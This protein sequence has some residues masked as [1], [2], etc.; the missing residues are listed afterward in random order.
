MMQKDEW[1]KP[2]EVAMKAERQRQQD[3]QGISIRVIREYNVQA[4]LMP[5]HFN[6]PVGND[7]R[8]MFRGGGE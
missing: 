4:D 1:P 3:Q 2:S 6:W 7:W 5:T 8:R